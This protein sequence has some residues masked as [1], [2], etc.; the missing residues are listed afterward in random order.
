MRSNIR[1]IIVSI[2]LVGTGLTLHAQNLE[3]GVKMYNFHRWVSAQKVLLPLAATDP[4]ANYYLGLTYLELHDIASATAT[5]QKYP[6]DPANIS[7]TA[8]V[9]FAQND[10]AKGMQILSDL[11]ATAKK[12]EHEPLKFAADA[13][14]YGQG[15]DYM[16]AI[17]WDS[18]AVRRGAKESSIF[19]SLGDAFRKVP[20]GGGAAMDNYEHAR[21]A[22]TCNSLALSRI[23]DLW[24]DAT[25][26]KLALDNYSKAKECDAT[27]PLPYK[28]LAEAFQRSGR[29]DKALEN[30]Q[31]YMKLSD[32]SFNDKRMNAET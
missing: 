30:M 25:N 17:A 3:T 19:I 5:F 32:N 13:I 9:A 14:I 18:A 22:E 11:A 27:N 7:G 1:K 16:Q 31:Q 12:K 20:G 2:A 4:R 28:A 24:F 26:Y 21:D 8:R 10:K 6:Q 15:G 23:G 29:Y